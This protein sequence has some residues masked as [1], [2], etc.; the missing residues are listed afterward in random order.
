M[1][2]GIAKNTISVKAMGVPARWVSGPIR[3]SNKSLA[4][5][6]APIKGANFKEKAIACFGFFPFLDTI[7]T[8]PTD[9]P[10][11]TYKITHNT[12]PNSQNTTG[13]QTCKNALYCVTWPLMS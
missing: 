8:S 5:I 3:L 1:P 2:K 6:R 12:C 9:P 10:L 7:S 13:V 11:L 4:F